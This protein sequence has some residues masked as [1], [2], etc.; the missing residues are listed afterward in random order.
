MSRD[1]PDWINPDKAAAAR[2]EFSGTMPLS[3]MPR[4]SGLIEGIEQGSINFRLSFA[5]DEQ[6]QVRIDVKVEGRVPMR[7]QRT[8]AIFEQIVSGRSVVAVVSSEDEVASLPDDYEPVLCPDQRLE[9]AA[10]VEEEVLLSLPLV[11]VD[12]DTSQVGQPER[13]AD[14]HR[15]FEVLAELRKNRNQD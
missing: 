1:F 14:T 15:P 9:L 6:N 5:R 3:R 8:L 11:P 7:C 2:R 12:P 10:L 13:L 4:L